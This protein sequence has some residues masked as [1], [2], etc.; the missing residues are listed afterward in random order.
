M[1][2]THP[3]LTPPH[4]VHLLSMTRNAS[5]PVDKQSFVSRTEHWVGGP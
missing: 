2:A 5:V 1:S 4:P 3:S